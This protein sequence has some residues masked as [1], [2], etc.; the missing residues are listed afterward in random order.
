MSLQYSDSCHGNIALR[1]IVPEG[2]AVP[3]EVA[4]ESLLAQG[5]KSLILTIGSGHISC[6]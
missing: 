4:V 3:L 1:E 5:Y 2:I 6:K